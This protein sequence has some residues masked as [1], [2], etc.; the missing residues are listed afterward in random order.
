MG[1]FRS[2]CGWSPKCEDASEFRLLES[3]RV[4]EGDV[5]H[6]RR[7]LGGVLGD[8]RDWLALAMREGLKV[9][10]EVRVYAQEVGHMLEATKGL[11]CVQGVQQLV[12]GV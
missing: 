2:H 5:H 3:L 10:L 7:R 6:N 12:H 1:H 9:D 11:M 8:A 4:V